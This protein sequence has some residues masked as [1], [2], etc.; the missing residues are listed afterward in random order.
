MIKKIID[1]VE[2]KEKNM[3]VWKEE[4]IEEGYR[5]IKDRLTI[6]DNR[7]LAMKTET[8]ENLRTIIPKSMIEETLE[9]LHRGHRGVFKM[10]TRARN[11][12]LAR[13]L[14]R[15]KIKKEKMFNV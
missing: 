8:G 12:V 15:F 11:S 10:M 9:R 7:I 13:N 3:E 5:R 14:Y 1:L 6:T 4:G 2:K